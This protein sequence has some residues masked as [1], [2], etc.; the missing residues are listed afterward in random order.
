ML[1]LTP[2]FP[3]QK[4]LAAEKDLQP[5]AD[6]FGVVISCDLDP[7]KEELRNRCKYWTL[8]QVQIRLFIP[9]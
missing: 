4:K 9:R 8:V 2:H 5:Q 1:T 3:G 6:E 7:E